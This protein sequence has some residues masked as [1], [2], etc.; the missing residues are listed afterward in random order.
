MICIHAYWRKLEPLIFYKD[1][2]MKF[3]KKNMTAD[4]LLVIFEI[5]TREWNLR[6]TIL[7]TAADY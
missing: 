5:I 3:S 1:L 7:F 4:G 6:K 2:A